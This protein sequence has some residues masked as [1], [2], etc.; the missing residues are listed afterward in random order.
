M[1]SFVEVAALIVELNIAG[2]MSQT[3]INGALVGG[4]SLKVDG[5]AQT[6]NYGRT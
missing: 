2:L 5:F 1:R 6:V 4:A 3:D